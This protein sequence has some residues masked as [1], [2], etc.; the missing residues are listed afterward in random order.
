MQFS[1]FLKVSRNGAE[2]T[3]TGRSLHMWAPATRKARRPIVGSLTAGTSRSS[4]EEDRSL[5]RDE[6]SAIGVNCRRYCGAMHLSPLSYCRWIVCCYILL[7]FI[8][9]QSSVNPLL[10]VVCRLLWLMAVS[11]TN[12]QSD[13]VSCLQLLMLFINHVVTANAHDTFIPLF[14][15]PTYEVTLHNVSRV[16]SG[17]F[18]SVYS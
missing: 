8:L 1:R 11:N 17:G 3:S 15:Q 2:V 5:S 4:D 14:S 13:C 18:L 12:V 10:S 16:I 9:T 6:I 7:T